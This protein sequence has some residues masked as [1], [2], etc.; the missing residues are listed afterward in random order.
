MAPSNE[1]FLAKFQRKAFSVNTFDSIMDVS[2]MSRAR[3]AIIRVIYH[4]VK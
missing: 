2:G 1:G 3:A 4:M